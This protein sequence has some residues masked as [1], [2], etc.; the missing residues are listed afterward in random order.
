MSFESD[1]AVEVPQGLRSEASSRF[2][3]REAQLSRILEG[4]RSCFL[5]SGFQGAS[6]GDICA[7]AGMSP[8]ALY[9][10]FP[11]KES[12]IE[13]ICAGD[14]E[15]DAKILAGIAKAPSIVDGMTM[16]LIAHAEQVHRTS[17][18]PLFAEI[19]A[20]A[21]RNPALNAILERS[22]CDVHEVIDAALHA[23]LERGE[24]DPVIPLN[25]LLPFMMAIGHGLVTHDLPSTGISIEAL[26]PAVRGMIVG[27]LRPT[28]KVPQNTLSGSDP[29]KHQVQND[30]PA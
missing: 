13:A 4:A 21:M 17:M 30:Q 19:F 22:M 5:K 3:R 23:A 26:E 10:Y 28:A 15:V 24:I 11:S 27:V 14:K 6:M 12:L 20:E 18:A 9:R 2:E 16:G 25:Q 7:V 8:G 1:I 29:G